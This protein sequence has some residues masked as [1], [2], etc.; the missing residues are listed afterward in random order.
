[1]SQDQAPRR[2]R[3]AYMGTPDFATPALEALLDS[4]HE[5]VGVFTQPDRRSGRGKKTR[6]SPVKRVA[7]AGDVEVFQPRRVREN[8]EAVEVLAGWRPDVAVVAAYG[9]ILPLEML[10]VPP[11]GCL[12]IHASLLP[13]YRGAAPINWCIV[14]G[15][16]RAGVTIMQMDEGLDTGPMLTRR[17]IEIDEL[18]T[19]QQLH[20][21]LAELGADLLVETLDG[22]LDGSVEPTP[23]DDEQASWA[24]MLSKDDGLVDW[25]Q[26]ARQ[27]ADHIRGL[28]PW[29]GAYTFHHG[30]D[31]APQRI[32][33][34]LA[35]PTDG[36]GEPGQV[37]EADAAADALVIACG[38]GAI[39]CLELQAPGRRAMGPRDFLNGYEMCPGDR[40][41]DRGD[42]AS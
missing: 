8:P 24:P 9:Q 21:Q 29:P 2:L 10:E 18:M 20:D 4:R 39:E 31:V 3:I 25:T 30:P 1:M 32:K 15:E 16:E 26:T 38:E 14:R 5:V 28:N 19:A 7:A 17:A 27:V 41:A 33:L 35:R 23:Q 36:Q 13:A 42:D 12:N 11:M 22:L 34:H 40:L 6:P 37:I